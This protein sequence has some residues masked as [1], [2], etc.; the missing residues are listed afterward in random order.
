MK[1]N[2]AKIA[3]AALILPAS[4]GLLSCESEDENP[5]SE[6]ETQ[7]SLKATA[8]QSSSGT[9]ENG[10]FTISGFTV[11]EFTVGT[12]DVAMKYYAS[13]DLVG[14]IDLGGIQ[15]KTTLNAELQTSSSER[16]SLNLVSNGETK[17]SLV[18][19]G[20]T[21]E[22]NYKQVS[23]SLYSNETSSDP[24]YQK[25]LFIT[26]EINGKSTQFWTETEKVIEA[27]SE[28]AS[29]IEV[30]NNTELLLS[31]EMEKLFAGVDF[32]NA[33]DANNDGKIEIRPNSPDGNAELLAKIEANLESSVVLKKR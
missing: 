9:S 3:F 14:G 30:E 23:F 15:L 17:V 4:L 16:K 28:S 11:N 20:N 1:L 12:Q 26:G 2:I 10:R 33:I 27:T 32:S 25:S 13:A 24:M 7:A 19:Q 21:P 31:F 29:G 22:G 6:S 5:T 8:T 18:G